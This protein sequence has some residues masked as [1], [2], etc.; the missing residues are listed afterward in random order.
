MML[1]RP[2]EWWGATELPP[3]PTILWVVGGAWQQT[4]ASWRMAEFSY[5]AYAGFQI[6][7]IDYRTINEATFPAQ[8]QDVKA[9]VR[10]LRANAKRYG[11]DPEKIGIM[12]DS[13]GGYLAAMIAATG[14]DAAFE[15]DE[16]AGF[17]SEVRAA[18][19][20]Y[21][22]IDLWRMRQDE[23]EKNPNS[24]EED[25]LLFRLFAGCPITEENKVL[26]ETMSPERYLSEKTPPH[27]ILH[28]T[29]D[30]MVHVRE[31]ERYYDAL[32]Q[33]GIPA[34]L[35]LLEGAGHCDQAFSQAEVQNIIL[36]FFRK[37]LQ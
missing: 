19:D 3:L 5:L 23:L 6:A 1:L 29:A 37:H 20:W 18:V 26:L 9:A 4:F 33:A 27:L 16:W 10:F 12:G 13:A 11:V 22:P 17:S 36:E 32:I 2:I 31:S 34:D 30:E 15:T 24:S 25:A 14:D 28:G 8:V 7:A 21:G 35:V